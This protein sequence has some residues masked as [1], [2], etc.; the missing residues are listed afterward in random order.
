MIQTGRVTWF[1]LHTTVFFLLS[2]NFFNIHSPFVKFLIFRK[3]CP[4]TCRLKITAL[5][6]YVTGLKHKEEIQQLCEKP[7]DK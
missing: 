6:S 3:D 7:V 2:R 5:Q 4:T 1:S